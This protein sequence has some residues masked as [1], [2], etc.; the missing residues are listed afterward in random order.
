ME[1]IDELM[2]QKFNSEDP[3]ERFEFQEEFWEQ[4]QV[5]LAQEEQR[6]RR[7]VGI[8][9]IFAL[10]FVL[11]LWLLLSRSS[12]LSHEKTEP[13][14]SNTSIGNT[15]VK[16]NSEGIPHSDSIE[17]GRLSQT[18]VQSAQGLSAD[19]K[20]PEGSDSGQEAK[21]FNAGSSRL[22]SQRISRDDDQTQRAK[23]PV[24]GKTLVKK[25]AG[26]KNASLNAKK[27]GKSANGITQKDGSQTMPGPIKP[28]GSQQ[29]Q[30]PGTDP[31]GEQS[32]VNNSSENIPGTPPPS[33][34][35]P[36]FMEEKAPYISV[37]IIPTPV[38]LF[39]LPA[40][41]LV[42]R[43]MKVPET[44][45]IAQKKDPS[46]DKPFSFGLSLAGAAYQQP[47]TSGLWAGF[48]VGAYG[49]YRLNK[50]WSVLLGGQWRFV[51]GLDAFAGEDSTNP[52]FVEQLRYSF[53]YRSELW[54]RETRGLHMLELP[55]AA[56]FN[57]GRW[58]VE[59]GGAVGMLFAV[60]NK[61]TYTVSS[62]LEP[63]KTTVKKYVKGVKTPYNAI[64][65]A[66]FAG[67]SYQ[68]N[69]RLSLLSRV[70]YRFTPVFKTDPEGSPNN[71]LGNVE[72][73]LRLRLF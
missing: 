37:F 14:D 17:T 23:D 56:K 18:A 57:Q 2:R 29:N 11:L 65:I 13:G 70:N 3:G 38:S 50:S 55:V 34:T 46:K 43:K 32:P 4:A 72:L 39:D 7:N 12:L 64:N 47:D 45:P 5:L 16:K 41:V 15:T 9:L 25:E 59:A 22:E 71:G 63:A 33:L 26:T 40:P 44:A 35:I 49:E 52:N 24:G 66:A 42:P 10:C 68:L 58:G 53:G 30:L 51:P 20:S 73:G 28:E 69:N 19:A 62:S 31:A 60:Q 61:T 54:K 48:S 6:R 8:F 21:G 67:A 1:N 27:T 36:V